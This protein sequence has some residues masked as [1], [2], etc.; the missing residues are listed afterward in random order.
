MMSRRQLLLA[1]LALSG[2][3]P[4]RPL[5]HEGQQAWQLELPGQAL[6]ARMWLALPKGYAQS[7]QDWPLVVFLHGSGE[8]GTDLEA[9]KR[10]G[11]PRL[12]AEGH[13]YPFILCSPQLD[14]TFDADGETDARWDPA[15]LH[16]LLGQLRQRL[17]VDD[18][19]VSVTGLSLGGHG[20][21]RW[22][23]VYPDELAAAVPICGWN[24]GVE[25]CAKRPVPV[26]A[27]HGADDDVVPLADHRAAVERQRAC[28]GSAEL[29]VYPGVGH[30]AW[31]PAYVDPA[32]WPWLLAQQ[33]T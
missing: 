23:S 7:A 8:C 13:D 11:P 25:A 12:V 19:R 21:W 4:T 32:L 33:R 9:V 2:C 26:R 24:D 30:G 17:R 6:P 18:R 16:A 22:L 31:I 28:G 14:G 29:T 20:A 1:P 3:G 15:W 27:Y 5:L 10:N